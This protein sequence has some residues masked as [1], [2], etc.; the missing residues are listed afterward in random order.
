M[1]S[2][3]IG[4]LALIL[5]ILPIG[6]ALAFGWYALPAIILDGWCLSRLLRSLIRESEKENRP[7]RT[8]SGRRG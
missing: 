8:R 4:W 3:L 5:T 1:R 7:D 6:M 2:I